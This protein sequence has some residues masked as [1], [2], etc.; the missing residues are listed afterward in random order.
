MR[1][2]GLVMLAAGL[3]GFFVEPGVRSAVY[4]RAW[5]DA[6]WMLLGLAVMG[7][8]FTVFPGKRG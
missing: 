2:T 6:R 3:A 5:E 7:L 4:A 1:R 8:F